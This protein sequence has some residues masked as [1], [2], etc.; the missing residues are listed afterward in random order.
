MKTLDND[1]FVWVDDALITCL[2]VGANVTSLYGAANCWW[3]YKSATGSWKSK[4]TTMSR[5]NQRFRTVGKTVGTDINDSDIKCWDTDFKNV[6]EGAD[7]C[8]PFE[9][10]GQDLSG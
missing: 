4:P 5:D 2:S 6:V 7:E 3:D 1:M 10:T 9:V 8:W